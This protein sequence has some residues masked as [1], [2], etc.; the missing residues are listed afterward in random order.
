MR[1]KYYSRD[2][3]VDPAL[4]LPQK[5]VLNVI[6]IVPFSKLDEPKRVSWTMDQLDPDLLK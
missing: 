5:G 2:G 4:Q 6:A 1:E 3:F